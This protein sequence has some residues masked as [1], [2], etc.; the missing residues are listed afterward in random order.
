[1]GTFPSV[2]QVNTVFGSIYVPEVVTRSFILGGRYKTDRLSTLIHTK[3]MDKG[4]DSDEAHIKVKYDPQRYN[5]LMVTATPKAMGHMFDIL[6]VIE[7]MRVKAS[8]I[9]AVLDSL[10]EG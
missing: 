6:T 8:T 5:V 7:N 1:M 3:L 4:L 10:D 9:K 2:S